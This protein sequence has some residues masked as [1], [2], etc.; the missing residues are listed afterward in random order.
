MVRIG[1]KRFHE[2]GRPVLS[3]INTVQITFPLK[4]WT[5]CWTFSQYELKM[6]TSI[7]DSRTG[8]DTR[9]ENCSKGPKMFLLSSMVLLFTGERYV[10]II[11]SK[12]IE[13][14][15]IG[16]WGPYCKSRIFVSNPVLLSSMIQVMIGVKDLYPILR[17]DSFLKICWGLMYSFRKTMSSN[18]SL[19]D[20]T[21]LFWH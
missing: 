10:N 8:F 7:D 3:I 13:M 17:F 18:I 12:F 9:N 6:D 19:L 21:N 5:I 16:F 20:D 2:V 4:K 15:K 1:C 14:N 11:M